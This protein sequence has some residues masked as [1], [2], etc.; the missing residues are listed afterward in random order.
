MATAL[1][2]LQPQFCGATS[3]SRKKNAESVTELEPFKDFSFYTRI[4]LSDLCLDFGVYVY[5][6][7]YQYLYFIF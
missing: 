3:L 2:P 6:V 1:S 4:L 5:C 7:I